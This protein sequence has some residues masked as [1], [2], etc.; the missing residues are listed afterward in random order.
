M[1]GLGVRHSFRLERGLA[2]G[3]LL[4]LVVGLAAVRGTRSRCGCP[5]TERGAVLP[6]EPTQPD[7]PVD[8]RALADEAYR[9]GDFERAA[10]IASQHRPSDADLQ[11]L[12]L[13]YERLGRAWAIGMDA[14]AAVTDRFVA[15]REAWKLDTVLGGAHG[16]LLQRELRGISL[17]AAPAFERAHDAAGADLAAHT[18]EILGATR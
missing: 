8:V 2:L 18:A 15:L 11:T 6:T 16:E 13:Q 7:V 4:G 3:A 14:S 17:L 5:Y 12:A 9:A 1:F 10:T